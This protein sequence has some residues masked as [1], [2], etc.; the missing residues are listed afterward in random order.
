MSAGFF[1]ELRNARLRYGAGDAK[2]RN[3]GGLGFWLGS[4]GAA[5]SLLAFGKSAL[6]FGLVTGGLCL[7]LMT[8][9]MA[10]MVSRAFRLALPSGVLLA[11]FTAGSFFAGAGVAE[12]ITALVTI[13][14]LPIQSNF[15]SS[16][17]L[18]AG[19]GL[20]LTC[21]SLAA[22]YFRF[23]VPLAV[24]IAATALFV[25][26]SSIALA[27]MGDDIEQLSTPITLLFAVL[28]LALAV[29]FDLTDVQRD[30]RRSDV[31]FWLYLLAGLSAVFALLD[32]FARLP[33]FPDPMSQIVV[34]LALVVFTLV[35]LVFDRR[36][37]VSAPLFYSGVMMAYIGWRVN[38]GGI[39]SSLW[40]LATAMLLLGLA[41]FWPALRTKL[42]RWPPFGRLADLV[43]PANGKSI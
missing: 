11:G 7:M 2:F 39:A 34:L 43:P 18:T 37:L 25:S 26:L 17:A 23:Q 22:F 14:P 24:A 28:V 30:T 9:I 10:E 40:L 19:I 20:L 4:V 29:R 38:G 36:L 15:D 21:L 1:A 42:L 35:G 3:V 32:D 8:W 5:G 27:L 13:E 33:A 6:T 41:W 12:Q 16:R 31:A